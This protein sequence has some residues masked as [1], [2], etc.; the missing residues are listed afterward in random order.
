MDVNDRIFA[1]LTNYCNQSKHLI[2]Y[3]AFKHVQT[4]ERHSLQASKVLLLQKFLQ[5]LNVSS[6]K[7]SQ[8][9]SDCCFPDE[10]GDRDGMNNQTKE[11]FT[12]SLPSSLMGAVLWAGIGDF[13]LWRNG[14]C[15]KT[16][17]SAS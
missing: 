12:A 7:R 14:D 2:T 5:S 10:A 4:K 17:F 8:F 16:V 1:L 9:S 15:S 13:L 3:S 11:S 6:A